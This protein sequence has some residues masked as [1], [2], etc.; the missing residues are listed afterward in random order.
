MLKLSVIVPV[1]NDRAALSDLLLQLSPE[2]RAG[3]IEV[4]VVDGS[5]TPDANANG[6]PSESAK[7][8]ECWGNKKRRGKNDER[9][10]DHRDNEENSLLSLL[11]RKHGAQLLFTAR[12][13]A[14]QMNCG[15]AAA[16]GEN[17]CF[18]HADSTVPD[19]FVAIATSSLAAARGSKESKEWGSFNVQL[20]NPAFVYRVISWFINWRSRLTGV[21]T[22][23]QGLLMKRHFFQLCGGFAEIPLMEDVE[24]CKR[25]RKLSSPVRVPTFLITSSRRWEKHGVVTT[26]LL[27]WRL[28]WRYFHGDSPARLAEQYYPQ[29]H[30]LKAPVKQNTPS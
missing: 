21:S 17:L 12:G 6:Q 20:S 1:L 7:K 14:K 24:F 5:G 18:L 11:C 4:I 28:R 10:N 19:S 3:Q 16:T 23:D 27:M 9:D 26:V 29:H 22:G 25:A 30:P 2:L 15:A 8:G 13:R